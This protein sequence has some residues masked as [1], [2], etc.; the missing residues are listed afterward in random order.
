MGRHVDANATPPHMLNASKL[1][2]PRP[3]PTFGP[4]P[5]QFRFNITPPPHRVN[6]GRSHE[7][8]SYELYTLTLLHVLLQ[9]RVTKKKQ[10]RYGGSSCLGHTLRRAA[11]NRNG[12][13]GPRYMA[14]VPGADHKEANVY[15]LREVRKKKIFFCGERRGVETRNGALGQRKME[16]IGPKLVYLTECIRPQAYYVAFK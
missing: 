1:R 12:V 16:G 6:N 10:K 11:R 2:V 9:V 8:L 13:I 4:P 3:P 15:R 5:I 14:C 7:Y